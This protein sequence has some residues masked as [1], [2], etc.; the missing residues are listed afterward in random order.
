MFRSEGVPLP[1]FQKDAM[2]IISSLT[3]HHT[4]QSLSFEDMHRMKY[5]ELRN[6]LN[7]VL[8]PKKVNL[9]PIP[10]KRKSHERKKQ[11]QNNSILLS[12]PALSPSS[13]EFNLSP[14]RR[15]I[16]PSELVLLREQH[17][18][19]LNQVEL[20]ATSFVPPNR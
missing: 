6:D 19:K 2:I 11:M 1:P 8:S 17:T 5:Q 13:K 18:K 7:K 15:T 14:Q 20:N 9:A 12:E 10:M 4:T 16:S 3:P